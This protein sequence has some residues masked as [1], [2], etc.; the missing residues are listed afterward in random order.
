MSAPT[1]H[2]DRVAPGRFLAHVGA[3]NLPF[4][5]DP[6]GTARVEAEALGAWLGY[7]RPRKARERAQWMKDQ[8]ILSDFEVCP[9]LGQT[10]R[11]GR[12]RT[13]LWLTRRAA[14]KLAARGETE[15]AKEILDLIVDVFLAVAGGATAPAQGLGADD[16]RRILREELRRVEAVPV[17]AATSTASYAQSL[18][19]P[20]RARVLRAHLLKSAKR[21]AALDPKCRTRRSWRSFLEAKVRGAAKFPAGPGYTFEFLSPEQWTD[22]MLALAAD[23]LM[24]ARLEMP[25][26]APLALPFGGAA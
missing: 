23:D 6:D 9:V 19:P 12:P 18:T 1:I 24:V 17:P 11:G 10:P 21:F 15:K 7:A 4:R 13:E 22:A 20:Q 16:V 26:S 3:D 8:G 25:T 14:L 2:I 5:V